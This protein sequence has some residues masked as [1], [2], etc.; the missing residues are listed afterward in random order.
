VCN[1]L[2]SRHKTPL[3]WLAYF[4]FKVTHY[5]LGYYYISI[6]IIRRRLDVR[7]L[8]EQPT[9]VVLSTTNDVVSTSRSSY[10]R[11]DPTLRVTSISRLF[12]TSS[13]DFYFTC[14]GT[15]S[16]VNTVVVAHCTRVYT[17]HR[18]VD[19]AARLREIAGQ[20]LK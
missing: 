9:D 15:I 4:L 16:L 13:S 19:I 1:A 17:R 8:C 10:E 6:E 7:T 14:S 20:I 2:T 5:I 3:N 11:R 18:C 12:T